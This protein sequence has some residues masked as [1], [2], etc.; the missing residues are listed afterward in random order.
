M[1][2]QSNSHGLIVGVMKLYEAKCRV[3]DSID[4]SCRKRALDQ[5]TEIQNDPP[6]HLSADKAILYPVGV[7]IQ[8]PGYIWSNVD[9]R[10]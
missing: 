1:K 2:E 7:K 8:T 6:D 5:K 3:E 10:K 9:D 4:V